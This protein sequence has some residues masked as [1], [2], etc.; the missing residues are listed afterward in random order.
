P[1]WA[2]STSAELARN[3]LDRDPTSPPRR[4][5]GLLS[6]LQRH[7]D[8][9]KAPAKAPSADEVRRA[10]TRARQRLIGAFVLLGIGVIGFPLLFETQPRP[11]PVDI[12][13]EIPRKD[14]APPLVAPAPR[15]KSAVK[16]SAPV[17]T[18]TAADAG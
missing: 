3:A 14:G 4:R 13:I 16:A 10:R 9:D 11:I 12:P 6:F 18:E 2:Q 5:M 1:G 8:A 15:P 7:R 17:I